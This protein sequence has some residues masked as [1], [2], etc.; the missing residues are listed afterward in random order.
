VQQLTGE[1]RAQVS[2]L[3]TAFNT[4]I[5]TTTD[6]RGAYAK[7]DALVTALIRPPAAAQPADG[8][9]AGASG[10]P[11]DGLDPVLK[12]KLDEFRTHLKEFETAANA[13]PGQ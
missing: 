9:T 4:L 10:V 3:I 7:V 2:Q 8:G 12:A 11:A 6:W 1:P 5:T 13:V